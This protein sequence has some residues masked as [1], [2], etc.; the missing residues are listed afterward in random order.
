M[1]LKEIERRLLSDLV[2]NSR[3]SDR[4]LAKAI[5]TSQPTAT[6]IRTKLEKEG[7][8]KEYTS[9]PNLR[10]VGYSILALTFTKLDVTLSFPPK[11]IGDFRKTH[12]DALSKDPSAIMLIKR[13]MNLGYDA[14]I[15]SFHKDY[16]SYDK[17][18]AFI[19]QNITE[20]IINM[21]T[22]L[23]NLDEEQIGLPF[24]FNLI[25]T[26]LLALPCKG[27]TG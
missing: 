1:S 19:Q 10:K 12:Y 14:V 22:F 6:R 20:R 25:A 21:D 26:Q 5:G 7:Y 23:I 16:S 9:I 11:D 13:G 24:S 2:K 3:R 8:V 15:M 27:K 18:R 17:F 4:E